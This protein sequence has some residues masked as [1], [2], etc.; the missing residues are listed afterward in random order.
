[1]VESVIGEQ[2]RDLGTHCLPH[3]VG[4]GADSEE[5]AHAQGRRRDG[6][7]GRGQASL[8]VDARG[9]RRRVSA[10]SLHKG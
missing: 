1:M 4:V 6:D 2:A 5:Q 8:R 3:S 9:A 7:S 10:Q